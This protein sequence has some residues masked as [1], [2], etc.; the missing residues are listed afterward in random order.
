MLLTL[1]KRRF[2]P[3]PLLARIIGGVIANCLPVCLIAAPMTFTL[4]P[5]QSTITIS[6]SFQNSGLSFPLMQQSAGS[7]TTIFGGTL[8]ADVSGSTIQ[9]TG[10]SVI[11]AQTNG[12][13]QPLPGGAA[14][15]APADFGGQG[16]GFGVTIKAALR[17][18][19]L[20]ATSAALPI[21]SGSFNSGGL[22]FGFPTSSTAALDYLVTG[23]LSASG[24]KAL[25][26]L[27]TN[28]VTTTATLTNNGSALALTIPVSADFAFTVITANDAKVT[29]TGKLVATAAA[30]PPLLVSSAT[31]AVVSGTVSF[32]WQATP[33]Q[34][35]RVESSTD[36]QSWTTRQTGLTSAT[37]TYT[38][39]GSATGTKEYFRLVQ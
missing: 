14:G 39:S 34:T 5:T 28:K 6:G 4:D 31:V 11:D 23:L 33:G 2:T 12:N 35:F 8:K 22:V 20:D 1:M 13:W 29:L 37:S 18:I 27:S 21:T 32:Q 19:V 15:S 16:G 24:G 36:L 25:Q 30:A 10:G 26:G 17:N 7:L 3:D 9:F 38:F